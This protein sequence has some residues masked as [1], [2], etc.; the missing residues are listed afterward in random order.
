MA[1]FTN[2]GGIEDDRGDAVF[3]AC[4]HQNRLAAGNVFQA[5]VLSWV[6]LTLP[7]KPRFTRPREWDVWDLYQRIGWRSGY[8]QD[9]GIPVPDHRLAVSGWLQAGHKKTGA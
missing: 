2:A 6:L 4:Q 7:S 3:E 8:C 1:A 9:V 5:I